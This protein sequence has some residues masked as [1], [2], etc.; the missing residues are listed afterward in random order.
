MQYLTI[1]KTAEMLAVHPNTIRRML[2]QLGAVDLT[3]G[4]GG[5]RL[6]RIPERAVEIYLR[7]CAILPPIKN[8]RRG[9]RCATR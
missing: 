6:V 8:E 9:K 4:R 5:K 3:N 2:P 7:D 1:E